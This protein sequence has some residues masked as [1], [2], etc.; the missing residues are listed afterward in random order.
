MS[1]EPGLFFVANATMVGTVIYEVHSGQL[2]EKNV[3]IVGTICFFGV[4]AL[5]F[6]LLRRRRGHR[7]TTR[8][9]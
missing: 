8:L 4:N 7:G 2:A 9:D 1:R 6:F 3:F 5:L